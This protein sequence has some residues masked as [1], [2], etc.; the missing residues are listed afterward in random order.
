MLVNR[1]DPLFFGD[2]LFRS[3]SREDFVKE[4]ISDGK[5]SQV[6]S[7]C[8]VALV[9]LVFSFGRPSSANCRASVHVCFLLHTSDIEVANFNHS[10]TDVDVTQLQ[11]LIWKEIASF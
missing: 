8:N 1:R 3:N 9:E 11:F 10:N 7:C 6:I 4:K 5:K 2:P